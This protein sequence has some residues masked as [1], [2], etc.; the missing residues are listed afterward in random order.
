[1]SSSGPKMFSYP[2]KWLATVPLGGGQY[3]RANNVAVGA[4]KE[5]LVLDRGQRELFLSNNEHGLRLPDVAHTA[6]A[7]V[8]GIQAGHGLQDNERLPD[9]RLALERSLQI[10][11]APGQHAIQ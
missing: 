1:M 9:L 3:D 10:A 8:P 6:R 4:T 11:S 2:T 7:L 5:G